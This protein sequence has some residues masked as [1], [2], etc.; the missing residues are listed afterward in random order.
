MKSGNAAI[1]RHKQ[2][3]RALR[4][5]KGVRGEVEYLGEFETDEGLPYYNT[6]ASELVMARSAP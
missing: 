6:D 3:G 4:L 5:F 2:E 1:L